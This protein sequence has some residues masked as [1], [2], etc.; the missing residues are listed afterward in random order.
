MTHEEYLMLHN[1]YFCWF[2]RGKKIPVF[3]TMIKGKP[4]KKYPKRLYSIDTKTLEALYKAHENI[5]LLTYII[6]YRGLGLAFNN[7]F[8][9][10]ILNSYV[11]FLIPYTKVQTQNSLFIIPTRRLSV[12]SNQD[13]DGVITKKPRTGTII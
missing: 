7:I 12:S 6:Y 1:K 10:L 5:P 3:E 4:L 9:E 13:R 2:L 8:C 11:N